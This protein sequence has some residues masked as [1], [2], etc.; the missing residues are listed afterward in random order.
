[1]PWREAERIAF[2]SGWPNDVVSIR[3]YGIYLGAGFVR[4]NGLQD[5]TTVDISI[6]DD[7]RLIALRFPKS[8]SGRFTLTRATKA[9]M[10]FIVGCRYE[11]RK[12]GIRPG[13]YHVQKEADRFFVVDTK[14]LLKSR[15]SAMKREEK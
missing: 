5:C 15:I 8:G 3:K 11:I 14:T 2:G 12:M 13:P 4:A 1:M 7:N 9:A 6:D 10:C